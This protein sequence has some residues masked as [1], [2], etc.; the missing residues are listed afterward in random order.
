MNKHNL[1]F[2]MA[3]GTQPTFLFSAEITKGYIFKSIIDLLAVSIQKTTFVVTSE[4]MFHRNVD[5]PNLNRIL[6][7]VEFPR[8]KFKSFKCSTPFSFAI[9]L[10]HLKTVVKNVKKKVILMLYI[11]SS[12]PKKLCIYVK[13]TKVN[14]KK[15]EK[16]NSDVKKIVKTSVVK[17]IDHVDISILDTYELMELPEVVNEAKKLWRVYGYPKVVD[18]L[19]FQ[20]IKKMTTQSKELSITMRADTYISFYCSAGGLYGSQITI[21]DEDDEDS[22]IADDMKDC[23]FPI[24][25]E[26]EAQFNMRT[27]SPLMKLPSLSPQMQFYAPMIEGYPLKVR[28]DAGS[29]ATTTIYIKD[30]KRIELE[31]ANS[32]DV[33]AVTSKN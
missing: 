20:P 17:V 9:N 21:G 10:K 7:D 6:I 28:V 24:V 8:E 22:A 33:S 14:K 2:G 5:D 3:S 30:V 15:D 4:G 16:P 13:P 11:L 27:V 18:S 29:I 32:I 1:S 26:Y 23:P 12:D 19:D 25:T 31:E